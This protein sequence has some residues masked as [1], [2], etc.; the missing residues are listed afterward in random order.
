MPLDAADALGLPEL[1]P[2]L[3]N[4]SQKTLGFLG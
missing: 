2:S 3:A 4:F 1:F